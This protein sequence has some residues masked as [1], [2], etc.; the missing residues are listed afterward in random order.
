MCAEVL[1]PDVVAPK[2]LSGVAVSCSET[3]QLVQ[4]MFPDLDVAVHGDLFFT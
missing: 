4:G 3:A 1:I 2:Y